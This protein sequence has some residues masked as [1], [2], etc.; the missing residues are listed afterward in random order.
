MEL[1][2]FGGAAGK[3]DNAATMEE[4]LLTQA[5]SPNPAK[6]HKDAAEW[7]KVAAK[8]QLTPVVHG[9]KG[10]GGKDFKQSNQSF[11]FDMYESYVRA[12]YDVLLHEA[13]GAGRSFASGLADEHKAES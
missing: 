4:P 7:S 11:D 13:C 2:T 1:S 12:E 8:S 10:K 5:G 9:G 3:Y 6:I